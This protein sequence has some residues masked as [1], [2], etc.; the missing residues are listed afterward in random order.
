MTVALIMLMSCAKFVFPLCEYSKWKI[1]YCKIQTMFDQAI[2][3]NTNTSLYCRQCGI[4]VSLYSL[5]WGHMGLKLCLAN[6][7]QNQQREQKEAAATAQFRTFTIGGDNLKQ[8]ENFKYSKNSIFLYRFW[9][10]G[11]LFN[12]AKAWKRLVD[13]TLNGC[14]LYSI[15]VYIASRRRATA[16]LDLRQRNIYL[17]IIPRPKT[18][19]S[20]TH[21]NS[22]LVGARSIPSA[23]LWKGLW[24]P[25]T[26]DPGQRSLMIDM[27]Q[28]LWQM[29]FCIHW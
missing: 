13:K 11:T 9:C 25:G 7:Y 28:A 5:S 8:V 10:N 12:L 22:A 18:E 17:Q 19:S 21:W 27:A 20:H 4:L 29:Q 2:N 24:F 26:C 15:Q 14:C 23:R 3:S 16:G 6:I 1:V